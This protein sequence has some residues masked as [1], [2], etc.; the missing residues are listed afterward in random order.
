MKLYS[1]NVIEL[2]GVEGLF[3]NFRTAEAVEVNGRTYADT[4][5]DGS[6]LYSGDG[7]HATE[8]AA[9]QEAAGKVEKIAALLAAQAAKLREEAAA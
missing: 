3:V 2:L 4:C 5:G 8:A 1:A 9:R 6:F 7:W